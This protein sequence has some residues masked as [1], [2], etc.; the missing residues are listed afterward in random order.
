MQEKY[1]S[2]IN[3]RI[4]LQ[5]TEYDIHVQSKS[6]QSLTTVSDAYMFESLHQFISMPL[7]SCSH[8]RVPVCCLVMVL[9]T[10]SWKE[11]FPALSELDLLEQEKQ[12]SHSPPARQS[13]QMS[14]EAQVSVFTSTHFT[15]LFLAQDFQVVLPKLDHRR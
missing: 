14:R 1:N 2:W 5:N 12:S 15:S 11:P 9:I 7:H 10:T 4:C 6:T 3:C 8:P 13:R